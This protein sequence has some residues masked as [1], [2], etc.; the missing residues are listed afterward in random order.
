MGVHRP[1]SQTLGEESAE[2][3]PSRLFLVR[4]QLVA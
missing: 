4:Y 3:Y 2:L 1:P